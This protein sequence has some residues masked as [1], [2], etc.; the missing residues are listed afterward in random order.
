MTTTSSD[1]PRL[2]FVDDEQP[3]LNGL[4]NVL[5]GD[6]GRWD[7]RFALGGAEAIRALE[8]RPADVVITDMRMPQM[9]GLALLR[10]VQQRWPRAARIVLSGYA[11]LASVAQASAVAHQYL[12]KPCDPEALKG[13]IDRS[14]QLQALLGS[15][16][17]QR[18]VGSLGA[19]PSTPRLYQALTEALADPDVPIKRLAALVEGNLAMSSRVLQ[20][21]NSAYYGLTRRVSSIEEALVLLGIGTVRQLALTLEV[22][23]VFGVGGQGPLSL[24]ELEQHGLLTARIARRIVGDP[25]RAETAFAAG[26]LHDCGKLVLMSRL[27]AQFAQAVTTARRDGRP[28][29]LVERELLG[30]N[31]A[32]VGGYL[33]GLWGLPHPIVEAVAFHHTEDRMNGGTLD[34]VVAVGAANLLARS[35]FGPVDVAPADVARGRL[36]QLAQERRAAWQQIAAAEVANLGRLGSHRS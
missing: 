5:H 36:E 8:E 7:L 20:F 6:R 31:H 15:E 29:H 23:Q 3:L 10:A 17:L 9:D 4:R 26:L 33:L 13:V 32:E 19:L 14:L 11:D 16:T 28:L 25:A 18:T 21:V 1:K 2:L 34:T 35:T 24:E 30:A 22:A 12:L 27:P